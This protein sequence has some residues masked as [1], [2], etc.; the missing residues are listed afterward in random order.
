MIHF[1][2]PA[3]YFAPKTIDEAFIEEAQAL[4]KAGIFVQN[5]KS[6]IEMGHTYLY[7]GWMK[8]P[9]EYAQWGKNILHQGGQVF[10]RA[11]QYRQAHYLPEWYPHLE[12]FTPKSHYGSRQELDTLIAQTGWTEFFVKD[13][14]KSLTTERGSVAHSPE[15]VHA[16]VQ[17][18][19]DWKGIEGGIC[20]RQVHDFITDSEKRYFAWMGKVLSPDGHVSS[21]VKNIATVTHLPFISIDLIQDQQGKEWLV[22]IGDGQVSDLKSPWTAEIFAQQLS[23]LIHPKMEMSRSFRV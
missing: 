6:P 19:E 12:A 2:Y 13:Y 7:R 8:T 4:E 20:L 5:E 1:V 17:T 10:T 14:V 9:D 22:E 23:S 21:L 11:E 16:I 15:D 3:D 18:I